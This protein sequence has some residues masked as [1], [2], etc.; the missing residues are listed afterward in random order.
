M[1]Y[2]VETGLCKEGRGGMSRKEKVKLFLESHIDKKRYM[3]DVLAG[4]TIASV[5][6]IFSVVYSNAE[7]IAKWA[8]NLL[9]LFVDDPILDQEY[10]ASFLIGVAI[11]LVLRI[12]LKLYDVLNRIGDRV[13]EEAHENSVQ[14]SRLLGSLTQLLHTLEQRRVED[15]QRVL[16]G[17]SPP[18]FAGITG[19]VVP[20]T[21][22]YMSLEPPYG[23]VSLTKGEEFPTAILNDD[24]AGTAWVYRGLEAS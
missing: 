8:T 24:E 15:A 10:L 18:K 4:L 14:M 22:V 20:A 6:A 16:A 11:V 5:I 19:E 1:M 7:R 12:L 9:A 21:G 2:S 3:T 17:Q 23:A 13:E